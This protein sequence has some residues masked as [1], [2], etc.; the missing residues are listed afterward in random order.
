M[1]LRPR[2]S[3]RTDTLFP[4]TTL[5]RSWSIAVGPRRE[6]AVKGAW[7]LGGDGE[8][9]VDLLRPARHEI[10]PPRPVGAGGNHPAGAGS[11]ARDAFY[12][13]GRLL[14]LDQ[15]P[16]GEP[17]PPASRHNGPARER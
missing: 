3:T 4:Y 5:F 7:M 2:R 16:G 1:I 17:P 11:V 6:H 9:G 10:G 13:F 15:S 14:E 8:H 12:I